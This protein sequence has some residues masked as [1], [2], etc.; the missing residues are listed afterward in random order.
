MK[1][2]RVQLGLRSLSYWQQVGSD[3][4]FISDLSFGDP[5]EAQIFLQESLRMAQSMGLGLD[6]ELRGT[7]LTLS[8][9]QS[10]DQLTESHLLLARG[11]ESLA[12]SSKRAPAAKS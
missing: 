7:S 10:G 8:L 11:V 3:L 6:V 12:S 4:S 9:A 1:P 5:Q 2:E